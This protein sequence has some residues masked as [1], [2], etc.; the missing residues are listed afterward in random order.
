MDEALVVAFDDQV[1]MIHDFTSDGVALEAAIRRMRPL[2]NTAL[3][4]AIALAS[5]KLSRLT[6]VRVSRRVIILISDGL[7]TGSRKIF[8]EA[9]RA[10]LMA[11]AVIFCLSTNDLKWGYSKGE[12]VLDLLSRATGGKF[13]APGRIM[14]SEK[15]S[16]RWRRPCACSTRLATLPPISSWMA[17]F[18]R[19][20]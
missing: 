2:G 7:D 6:D 17:A 10:V 11:D 14:S 13:F 16:P 8:T 9:Q 15:R 1:R 4:D 20:R 18:T 12:A 19:Y 5:E 3:Y